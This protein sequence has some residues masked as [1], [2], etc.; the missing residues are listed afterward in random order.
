MVDADGST[1]YID[2]AARKTSAKGGGAFNP[3]GSL[4]LGCRQDLDGARFYGGKLD[5]TRIYSKALSAAEV[6]ALISGGP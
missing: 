6:Q 2:G 4:F 1:V 5:D 3:T